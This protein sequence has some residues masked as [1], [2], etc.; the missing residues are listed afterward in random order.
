MEMFWWGFGTALFLV[1][2]GYAVNRLLVPKF[3]EQKWY[4]V[5]SVKP[6]ATP[7]IWAVVFEFADYH[8]A[9]YCKKQP[10][11][12]I[13]PDKLMVRIKNF[14]TKINLYLVIWEIIPEVQKEIKRLGL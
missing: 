9:G 12:G 1:I 7:G 2:L 6:T 3:F 5:L 11:E 10:P 13:E 4:K 14:N 8:V